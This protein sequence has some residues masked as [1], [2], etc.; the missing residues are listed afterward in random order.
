MLTSLPLICHPCAPAPFPQQVEVSLRVRS[1]E[2]W[3]LTFALRGNIAALRVPLPQP[4]QRADE[5]WR[6]TCCEVFIAATEGGYIEGNFSPSGEW[7]VYAFRGYRAGMSPVTDITPTIT[8]IHHD[9]WQLK[10]DVVLPLPPLQRALASPPWR[11]GFSVVAENQAGE[12]FYWALRHPAAR[13]DFHH[14]DA[15]A[16]CLYPR[17]WSGAPGDGH[18]G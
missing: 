13:P 16:L 15:F 12:V 11:L 5:L 3:I 7:A 2:A 18:A 9:S 8:V 1:T 4:S 14:P 17:T 10:L 6:H